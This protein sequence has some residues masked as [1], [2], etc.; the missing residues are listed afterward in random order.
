MSDETTPF[1]MNEVIRRLELERHPEGGWYRRTWTDPVTVDGRAAST[2]IV[3]LLTAGESSHWHRID[4][5][6]MWHHYAGEPVE[7]LISPDGHDVDYHVLGPDVLA[8]QTPQVV[9]PAGAWQSARPIGS[10][11]LLGCTVTPGFDPD[12]WE[13]APPG[14]QP[15]RSTGST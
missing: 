10:Y 8:G 7:L 5:V 14:W 15:S 4:S 13:L 1:E 12:G 2:A 11:S 3:Y 9:V 6:E